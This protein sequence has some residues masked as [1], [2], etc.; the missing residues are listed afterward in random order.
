M[1]TTAIDLSSTKDNIKEVNTA[2][3]Q[4]EK[5]HYTG[6]HNAFAKEKASNNTRILA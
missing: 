1:V 3:S 4:G 5:G 6:F 2:F